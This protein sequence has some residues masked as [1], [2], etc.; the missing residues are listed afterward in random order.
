[1]QNIRELS[2]KFLEVSLLKIGVLY[3]MLGNLEVHFWVAILD[4]IGIAEQ[5]N[6]KMG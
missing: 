5:S 4:P 6:M 2:H 3:V 1:M